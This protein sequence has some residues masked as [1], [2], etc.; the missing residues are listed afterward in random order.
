MPK[1]TYIKKKHTLIK[2]ND[3]GE[4]L[5]IYQNGKNEKLK[6]TH[7]QSSGEAGSVVH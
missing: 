7:W 1:H 2:E 3:I 4:L 5:L 6:H